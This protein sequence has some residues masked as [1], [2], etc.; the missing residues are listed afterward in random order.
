M[1]DD[2]LV[3]DPAAL[4][5]LYGAPVEASIVKQ[6]DRVTPEYR[7][8]IEAAPFAVLATVGPGGLDASPRGDAPGFVHVEDER[9]LMLPDRRGNNRVDSL[10]N[11]LADPRVG[12]LF[13]LPG[14]GETLRVNGTAAV[15]VDPALLDR[16]AVGGK[17]PRTVLVMRVTEVF[18]QCSR[19]VLRAG[20]WDPARHVE[21]ARIPTPGR[22]LAAMSGARVGGEAY[23]AGL[24]ER[25]RGSLYRRTP[26]PPAAA[27]AAGGRCPRPVF[28]RSAAP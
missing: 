26:R 24:Q 20:L 8:W 5:A 23:D 16:F 12:L 4:E 13:L 7:A 3:R 14:L 6:A 27:P 22:I 10:R 25:L 2:H 15:S 28:E 21:R 11:V 17:R 1:N 19:A 18:F 9:T